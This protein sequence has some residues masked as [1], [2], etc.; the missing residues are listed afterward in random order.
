M[1]QKYGISAVATCKKLLF[2]ISELSQWP[3]HVANVNCMKL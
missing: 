1:L 2:F 3:H